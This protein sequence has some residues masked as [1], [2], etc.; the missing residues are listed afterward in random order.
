MLHRKITDNNV[1]T[2]TNSRKTENRRAV[3]GVYQAANELQSSADWSI[4]FCWKLSSSLIKSRLILV[5]LQRLAV[6]FILD[7]EI[8][9]VAE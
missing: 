6:V 4:V 7:A 1:P 9:Y 2:K 8:Y 3:E 5:V